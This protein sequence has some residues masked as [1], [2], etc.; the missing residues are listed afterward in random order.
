MQLM[1]HKHLQTSNQIN[2]ATILSC[3]AIAVITIVY[4]A[5]GSDIITLLFA[6]ATTTIALI[7]TVRYR[8]HN[9][10]SLL[11]ALVAI[12]YAGFPL[13]AKLFMGQP[14]DSNLHRPDS[15]YLA[16]LLGALAYAVS[17]HITRILNVGHPLLSPIYDTRRLRTLS[18]LALAIGGTANLAV[19]SR[20]TEGYS[21]LTIAEF[22]IGFVHLSLIAA[23]A[24]VIL[25]SN[26]R[27]TIDHTVIIVTAICITFA[28]ILNARSM[29]IN[30]MLAYI[31]TVAAFQN[32][33]T[34][35][36]ISLLVAG[37]IALVAIITPVFLTV[38]VS[39]ENLRWDDRLAVTLTAVANWKQTLAEYDS[40]THTRSDHHLQYYG[41]PNN[42]FERASFVNHVDSMILA[43]ELI[44][45]LGPEDLSRSWAKS[46]PRFLSPDKQDL[47]NHGDWINCALDIRCSSLSNASVPLIA[48]AYA[49]F[50]WLGVIV[51]PVIFG[52]IFLVA[53]KKATGLVLSSNVWAVFLLIVSHNPF[54]EGTTSAY[55]GHVIRS[56]PQSV[57]LMML[58]A[59]L[60]AALTPATVRSVVGRQ[61]YGP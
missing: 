26:Y 14:L 47:V 10:A 46:L 17:F 13:L 23:V 4:L 42:V 16:V 35:R 20:L 19:F 32:R 1:T 37:A 59:W 48:N 8:V 21:G 24:A 25:E 5:L 29:V 40:T 31:V 3:S 43:A 54:V 39:R 58:L 15:A 57:I 22:F 34:L 61:S 7:F 49:A 50:G 28:T 53:I 52:S 60:S 6:T 18:I 33:L 51:Y 30:T 36:Q 45:H 41:S 2:K 44:G 38:R 56:I 12:R 55:F 11:V 27:R 9:I